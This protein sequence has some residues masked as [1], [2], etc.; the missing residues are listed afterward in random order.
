MVLPRL[1]RGR[2]MPVSWKFEL[3]GNREWRAIPAGVSPRDNVLALDPG[4]G[5]PDAIADRPI[6]IAPPG[7]IPNPGSSARRNA[8]FNPI[9]GNARMPQP[10]DDDRTIKMT[11]PVSPDDDPHLLDGKGVIIPAGRVTPGARL[12]SFGGGDATPPATPA[13][14]RGKSRRIRVLA[15]TAP[16]LMLVV[17]A[18]G[19]L[20]WGAFDAPRIAPHPVIVSRTTPAQPLPET[21]A[22]AAAEPVEARTIQEPARDLPEFI[23]E[24]ATEQ[25]ILDHVPAEGTTDPVIFSF[26]ANPRVLVFDFASLLNQGRMLNRVAALIEKNGVPHDHPLTDTELNAAVRASG[27]TVETFYYGHDYSAPSLTRFFFLADRDGLRLDS[28]E[29]KLRRVIRQEGWTESDVDAALISI[30]QVGADEHVTRQARAAILHHELSH[31]EYF[32]NPGYAAFV[33]RFWTQ[34]LTPSERDRIRRYLQSVGYDSALEEVME[35][36]AQAYLMFTDNTEFF[37]PDMIGMGKARLGELRNGFLRAMPAGWL[38]DSLGQALT[39]TRSAA[40]AHP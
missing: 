7:F 11:G 10:V 29:D 40:P 37:T 30:P 3:I 6:F 4:L 9:H 14:P 23:I 16:I 13:S 36:E 32:T 27:D 5:H 22:P 26:K 18:G 31:G 17:V 28:E 15:V 35:N 8:G 1:D 20:L 34:T 19:W 38:R 24:T 25:Q 39:A 21:T 33:H 2:T 12:R